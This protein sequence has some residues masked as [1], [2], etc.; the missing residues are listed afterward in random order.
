LHFTRKQFDI[1]FMGLIFTLFKEEP[2]ISS[3]CHL[4]MTQPEGAEGKE[5]QRSLRILNI[6][7]K[8][9]ITAFPFVFFVALCDYFFTFPIFFVFRATA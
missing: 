5:A 6:K 1:G 4:I 2:L 9:K 7:N 3:F 8:K